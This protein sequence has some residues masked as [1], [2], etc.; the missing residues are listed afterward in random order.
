MPDPQD[1]A[2]GIDVAELHK[3]VRVVAADIGR[4]LDRLHALAVQ[5]GRTRIGLATH[6]LGAMQARTCWQV[7]SARSPPRD[8]TRHA[9]PG[10]AAVG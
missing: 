7:D 4:L 1:V 10:Q 2:V 8:Q 9:L 5:D 6:A 3:L